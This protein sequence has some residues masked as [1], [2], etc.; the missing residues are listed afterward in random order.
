MC[1]L[2]RML[3]PFERGGDCFLI[4]FFCFRS[5]PPLQEKKKKQNDS[6]REDGE[7]VLLLV[8]MRA[9]NHSMWD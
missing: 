3:L 4:D 8:W 7:M 6:K 2:N 5:P 1:A 9:M